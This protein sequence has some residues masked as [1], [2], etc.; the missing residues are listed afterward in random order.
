MCL[1]L[2]KKLFFFPKQKYNKDGARGFQNPVTDPKEAALVAWDSD[3]LFEQ[4]G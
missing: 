2:I 1:Q 3:T 4:S